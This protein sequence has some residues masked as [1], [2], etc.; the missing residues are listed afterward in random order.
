MNPRIRLGGYR[1]Y[2]PPPDL[3]AHVD[4]VWSY[5]R[6]FDAAPI[7]GEGH[8]VIPD[9]AL[10]VTFSSRRDSAGRVLDARLVIIGPATTPRFF[11]P[12]AGLDAA[13]LRLHP[14]WARDLLGV[15]PTEH[16]DAVETVSAA[17][18]RMFPRA[19]DRLARTKSAEEAIGV[20]LE[21]LRLVIA[22]AR[23]SR[24]S[25]LAHVGREWLSSRAE[26]TLS[27]DE[28]SNHAGVSERHLRRAFRTVTGVSPKQLHRMRRVARVVLSADRADRPEWAQFA[29]ANGFYDQSH[30]IQ[31]FR[32]LTGCSPVQ[33]HAERRMQR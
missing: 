3:R 7:P 18:P 15:D 20:L 19:F 4:G 10:S 2:A 11:S 6:P 1:E 16:N 12:S 24:E 22:S 30:M 9:A 28:L 5:A 23:I 17:C 31:E 27:L 33:L 14:E 25:E 26:A 21:E 13:G 29:V 8:R 32:D